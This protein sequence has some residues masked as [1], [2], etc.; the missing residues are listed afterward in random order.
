MELFSSR[1][2]LVF[3]LFSLPFFSILFSKVNF[4]KRLR[5]AVKRRAGL[6]N[7]P[8]LVQLYG[9]NADSHLIPT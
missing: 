9:G 5:M 8:V 4:R 2:F 1:Y 6:L 7:K 3:A